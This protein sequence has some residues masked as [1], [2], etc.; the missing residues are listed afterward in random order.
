MLSGGD[1]YEELKRCGRHMPEGRV[2]GDVIRPCLSALSYLHAKVRPVFPLDHHTASCLDRACQIALG[3]PGKALRCKD[4]G[5]L[6][7]LVGTAVP[8]V[9]LSGAVLGV[10]G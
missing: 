5:A 9:A 1:L 7:S 10:L 3:S 2:A 4:G 8:N 6:L